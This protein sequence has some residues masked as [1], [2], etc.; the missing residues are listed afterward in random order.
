MKIK[1]NKT[2]FILEELESKDYCIID[3]LFPER[4]IHNLKDNA[5]ELYHKS[6]FKQAAIGKNKIIDKTIRSDHIYWWNYSNLDF[7]EKQYLRYLK[8]FQK[9]F[10]RNFYLS[11][12]FIEIFYS[13][14][15]PDTFYIKH[16]DNFKNS[17]TRKITF[18]TYL[19]YNWKAFENSSN[20]ELVLYLENNTLKVE[21]IFNRTVIFFSEYVPHE[22][23]PAKLHRFAITS[24][25]SQKMF[26]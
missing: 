25:F 17:N 7:Y 23:L 3:D 14:Y 10:N 15:E 1:A 11:T 8:L 21:P 9:I 19:N 22:V 6:Y 12:N 26:I 5:N 16:V 4:L 2:A 18:I 20:G 24:W 13:V